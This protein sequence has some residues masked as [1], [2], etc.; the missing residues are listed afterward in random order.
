MQA[1][2]PL[3]SGP[4]GLRSRLPSSP[5][6]LPWWGLAF[7]L[8]SPPAGAL[9]PTPLDAEG[10]YRRL[11]WVTRWDYRSPED[12]ERICYNAASAR[13]TD[14]L[15]QVRGEGT[16]FFRSPFEPWA[17]E[18]TARAPAKGLGVDPGWDPLATAIREGRRRGLRVHAYVNVLPAWAQSSDPPAG[19]GQPYADHPSW[20]MVDRA[21]RRMKPEGF[22]A[23][24][25]PSLPEV[26]RHLAQ[27]AARLVRDY[28]VDGVHLDYIR[29]PHE[30][31]D[32][33]YHPRALAEFRAWYGKSPAE[34]PETWERYRQHQVTETVRAIREAIDGVR[35]GVELSAAVLANIELGQ[36]KAGQDALTW[37]ARGYVDAIAPMVYVQ[38]TDQFRQLL[39]PILGRADRGRVWV[40]IRSVEENRAFL[41]QIE[42]AAEAFAGGI[43]VFSYGTVFP[44]HATTPQVVAVYRRFVAAA[45]SAPPSTASWATAR[46]GG[47]L[48]TRSPNLKVK[49]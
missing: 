21:G 15:F 17:W 7:I 2:L 13:F 43:A 24:L 48:K 46:P 8:A 3:P 22:Y 5:R 29:Y 19:H 32:F 47:G 36:R 4:I 27:L 9:R 23:F 14:L 33:S 25:D 30:S 45:P 31:G 35:L 44:G 26:R 37:L 1:A 18:L 41:P 38:T 16:V 42:L 10:A 49:F 12:I 6:L 39:G 34:L 40:G 11:L 28:P 20:L